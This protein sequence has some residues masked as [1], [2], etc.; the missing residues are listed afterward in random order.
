MA[1]C[2]NCGQPID[3]NAAVCAS[4]GAAQTVQEAAPQQP[5]YQ[6]APQQAAPQQPVYQQAPQQAA[7]QQPVYQQAPQAQPAPAVD[8]TEDKSLAWLSYFGI[9]LLIPL[10]ARKASKF[11]QYHVRQGAILFA[12]CLAYTIVTQVLLAIINAVTPKQIK[13]LWYVPYEAPSAIYEV[14]NIIFSLGSIFFLVIAIIGIVNA[15][16]GDEKEL[17][18]LGKIKLLEPLMDKIYASLNK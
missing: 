3:D 11:C 12:A 9:L 8:P 4:C 15:V 5:V 1:F 18:V 13:Y 14:F 6:Q 16:K 2:R 17:P 10:F 7:P